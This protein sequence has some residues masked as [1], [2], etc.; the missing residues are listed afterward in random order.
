MTNLN[1]YPFETR[2]SCGVECCYCHAI[3]IDVCIFKNA[4]VAPSHVQQ[5]PQQV[6]NSA[7]PRQAWKVEMV[8]PGP[9]VFLSAGICNSG[10]TAAVHP[11]PQRFMDV[12]PKSHGAD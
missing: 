4:G 7:A 12:P 3:R 8:C 10:G 6:G 9:L 2:S 11:A 1:G 5:G